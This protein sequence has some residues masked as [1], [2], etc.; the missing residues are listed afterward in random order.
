MFLF[1]TV[2]KWWKFV[3]RK[4]P[5]GLRT[6]AHRPRP[7]VHLQ[8]GK[9]VIAGETFQNGRTIF[10]FKVKLKGHSYT[11]LT[12]KSQN[13]QA[14]L[15]IFEVSYLSSY[16]TK[17]LQHLTN[18]LHYPVTLIMPRFLPIYWRWLDCR[19][20]LGCVIQRHRVQSSKAKPSKAF[21][22]LP[23]S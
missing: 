2:A 16:I 5:L 17:K 20:F 21:S 6:V 3:E 11:T 18:L 22:S 23:T 1:Q 9:E 7:P 14:Y 4:P 12:S 8:R 19:R 13:N 10:A 15:R